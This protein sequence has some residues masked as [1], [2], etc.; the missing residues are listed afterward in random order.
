MTSIRVLGVHGVGNRQSIMDAPLAARKIAHWWNAALDRQLNLAG[1]LTLEVVYYADR[2]AQ[3]T[4]QGDGSD[5]DALDQEIQLAIRVWAMQLGARNEI[6]HG[7]FTIP[8]RVSV[9]WVART[10]GLNQR[11]T[12]RFVSTFFPEV[13]RYMTDQVARAAVRTEI[14]MA[15][16]RIRPDILIAHSLGSVAAYESLWM[17]T[18]PDIDLLLTLGSPLAMPDI[19]YERLTPD[20]GQ[21]GRPPGVTRWINI[22]DPGDLIAIPRGGIG[23]SFTNVAADITDV[24]HAFDFHRVTNYL[25][26][27]ATTGIISSYL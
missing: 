10:F 25:T 15:L 14:A 11:L 7:R 12:R 23:T 3:P 26:C 22:A 2:L 18:H 1:R 4:P 27:G 24:I 19:I 17:Q 8:A 9:D 20:T 21:R 5:I 6:S 13:H 16:E